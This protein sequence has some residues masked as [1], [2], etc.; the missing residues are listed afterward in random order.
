M[1]LDPDY[2]WFITV[3]PSF[4]DLYIYSRDVPNEAE[5]A[6]LVERVRTLGYPVERLEFPPQPPA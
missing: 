4:R 2:R 1:A 6:R 5:R 3:D